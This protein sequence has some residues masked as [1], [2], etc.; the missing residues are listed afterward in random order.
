MIKT[1]SQALKMDKE[2]FRVPKSVQQAVPIRRIWPD[3]I[4]QVGNKYSKSFRF[5]DINYA[6]ASKADKTEMFLD[7]SELLNALDSG[8]SAKITLNNRRINKEEFEH[9]L[10]I[11]MKGDGLDHYRQEYN[12]MLLSKVSGTS[13]SNR[14]MEK[15]G[16]TF[17]VDAL[18]AQ[19]E[20]SA[21]FEL[22]PV[23]LRV[24][25]VWMHVRNQ[26]TAYT[27]KGQ[28]GYGQP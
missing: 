27:I 13:N 8:S 6:I 3:G 5:T 24:P 1:L 20:A 21:D 12:D 2:R 18:V 11:P 22:A 25:A 10:L 23:F 17:R 28:Y 4:F 16:E 14:R 15:G 19:A 7:Y 9:S 26:G